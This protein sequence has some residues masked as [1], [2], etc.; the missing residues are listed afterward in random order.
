[1]ADMHDFVLND[2]ILTIFEVLKKVGLSYSLSW[3]KGDLTAVA[4]KDK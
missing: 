4:W 2:R 1:V 3:V